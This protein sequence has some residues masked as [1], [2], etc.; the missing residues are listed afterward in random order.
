MK[1]DTYI[2]TLLTLIALFL[3]V[4]AADKIYNIAIPEAQASDGKQWSCYPYKP[5]NGG[6]ENALD[7]YQSIGKVMM[8]A[9]QVVI[10]SGGYR[11]DGSV[12]YGML[13]MG[14]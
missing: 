9:K 5:A 11:P 10:T 7:S 4:L 1:T 14:K 12:V 2:K 13:C 3:G 8:G 6:W